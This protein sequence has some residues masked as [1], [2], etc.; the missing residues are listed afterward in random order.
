MLTLSEDEI[1]AAIAA[2][3]T[4]EAE[5]DDGSIIVRVNEYVPYV[6]SSIHA[7]HR[8]RDNLVDNCLIDENARLQEEDP[9]TDQLI[10]SF[11]ITL[12]ARDSRYEYD[13]NRT[14]ET[15]VYDDLWGSQ[16][17]RKP[18]SAGQ[19]DQSLLKH[20]RYYRILKAL[21]LALNKKF[22]G[23]LLVDV[24]SYNWQIRQ[25]GSA[26]TFNVGTSQINLRQWR[27]TL[28]T[29]EKKLALVELP[30]LETTVGRNEVFEGRG[31]QTRFVKQLSPNN[32]VLPLDIKKIFMDEENGE[33]FPLVLEKLKEGLYLAVLDAASAFNKTLKRSSLKRVDLLP[34]NVEPI[35]LNVDRALY[36]LAKSIETL[37][38]VNPINIQQE[39]RKFLSRKRYN[40]EF[41]YRQ[42][43]IDPYDFREKLYKLPVS[44]IQEPLVR[45]LYRSVIDSYATKIE[46][47]THVGT[48]QFLYNSLRYYGEPSA[49]DIANARFLLHACELPD[50]ADSPKTISAEDAKPV[51]E[52]AAK[53]YGLDCRVVVSSRIVAKAMVDNS[54]R[55]LLINRNARLNQLEVDAL[56][57]HELGVHMVTTMNAIEQPL[58]V[59]R[60]GL[61]G[62]TYTQEGLA[63]LSEHLSGNMNL[64]RLK[65]LSLRV[66]AVEMMI[67]GMS[68]TT[69]FHRLRDDYGTPQ[70]EA[71]SLTVRVF[72]GGGFTKDYL[73]L[74]GFRDIVALHRSRNITP[75]LVG[76]TGLQS[77][78]TLASLIER[79]IL[80]SPTHLTPALSMSADP[81]N[82]LLD[83]LV[84]S[85][86]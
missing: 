27:T 77:L 82:P 58:Q 76:K 43:R 3:D 26:P 38:Y 66:L 11:P 44:Q 47:L 84:A 73:Y 60:L 56:I 74:S 48:P 37:H 30:N 16:V 6:C 32:L 72:R 9:F 2:G 25:Y 41:H 78:D 59:L 57:H 20:A 61:P 15:C 55:T 83:Y 39:K 53:D 42:L 8:L 12:T 31:Y 65:T 21:M 10:D 29:F 49:T 19:S 23:A 17:W 80:Q 1:V 50:Y 64:D 70:D 51:F 54:R 69:V 86:K 22:G 52:A 62:N 85:I 35:V 24:R 33:C 46:M 68:F 28:S 5:L 79:G 81:S 45:S 63:I 18:L 34:S 36:R 7:G 75:L 4:F 67:N 14:P 13:L 71:F 40:P